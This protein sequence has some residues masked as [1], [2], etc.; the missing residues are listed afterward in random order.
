MWMASSKKERAR[1][2]V[3]YTVSSCVRIGGMKQASCPLHKGSKRNKGRCLHRMDARLSLQLRKPSGKLQ[4]T[5]V[6]V[7]ICVSR[8][9]SGY[10]RMDVTQDE[11]DLFLVIVAAG[12]GEENWL[13]SWYP[14]FHA[15]GWIIVL[16]RTC[17]YQVLSQWASLELVFLMHQQEHT[18]LNALRLK[19]KIQ[20][21]TID[22]NLQHV[23]AHSREDIWFQRWH[24]GSP[25]MYSAHY[26][27][28][29]DWTGFSISIDFGILLL[30]NC[31]PY[32]PA[33]VPS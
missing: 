30:V 5:L 6:A 21:E 7:D 17:T 33:A 11:C 25:W 28:T 13:V 16:G 19:S 2:Q 31:I 27:G 32:R 15:C 4:R 29:E 24:L 1:W 9:H 14:S 26:T 3:S 12:G 10:R 8:C 23:T 20:L 18:D 22:L